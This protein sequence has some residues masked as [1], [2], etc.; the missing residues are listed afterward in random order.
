LHVEAGQ[1][2]HPRLGQRTLSWEELPDKEIERSIAPPL[3]LLRS[4]GV[5]RN[6]VMPVSASLVA[7]LTD[8]AAGGNV[9]DGTP[10]AA[11]YYGT[12]M[13]TSRAIPRSPN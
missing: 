8:A 6:G 5:P 11:S 3:T 12:P 13:V 2:F 10:M 4:D 9:A 7:R 1:S